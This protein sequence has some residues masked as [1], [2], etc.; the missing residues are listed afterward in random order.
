MKQSRGPKGQTRHHNYS[1]FIIH[2]SLCRVRSTLPFI[3]L[4]FPFVPAG[5][6][7]KSFSHRIEFRSIK[8]IVR[9]IKILRTQKP[10]GSRKQSDPGNTKKQ[11]SKNSCR[12]HKKNLRNLTRKYII[13]YN[14][15]SSACFECIFACI[16]SL[17]TRTEREIYRAGM[18]PRFV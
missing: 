18:I 17:G 9:Q 11:I 8:K 3:P 2:C 5:L 1:L 6:V 4:S 10:A 12:K 15:R 7:K 16:S 13:R 14:C